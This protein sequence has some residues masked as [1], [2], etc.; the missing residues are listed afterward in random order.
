MKYICL[1]YFD[2]KTWETMSESEQNA[3]LD[4]CFAYDDRLRKDGHIVSG[5]ALQSA[6]SAV[7]LRWK[8][9]KVSIT[10]GPYAETK[11]Q[12]GGFGVFEARDLNHA[13]ELMSKHPAVKGSSIEIR[14][15]DDLSEMIRAS[16]RRRGTQTRRGNDQ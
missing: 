2:E 1:G 4:E 15:V 13:I 6:R 14:P 9:S 16:E 5:E 11:E 12:L 8:S 10:D 3:F 7:T